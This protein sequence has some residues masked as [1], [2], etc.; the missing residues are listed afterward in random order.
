MKR[1]ELIKNTIQFKS[2]MLA[3]SRR[4]ADAPQGEIDRENGIVRN[5]LVV[6]VGEAQGHGVFCDEQFVQDVANY[7][8][9]QTKGIKCRFG[10]PNMCGNDALGTFIGRF[11]NFRAV[12]G[13]C[14][15]DLHLSEVA[16]KSPQFAGQSLYD[17]ILEMA[18]KESDMFG[19]SIVFAIAGHFM[20]DAKGN[21]TQVDWDLVDAGEPLYVKF[22][23]LHACDCV[24]TPA[25]T[26][27]A[28]TP[29]FS[30]ITNFDSW[31]V[32]AEEYLNINPHFKELIMSNNKGLMGFLA[33]QNLFNFGK[34]PLE[35]EVDTNQKAFAFAAKATDATGAEVAVTAQEDAPKIGSKLFTADAEGNNTPAPDGTYAMPIDG[36]AKQVTVAD[37]SI[38]AIDAV[39]A[40][41][42][43]PADDAQLSADE[44]RFEAMLSGIITK[45]FSGIQK[46]IDDKFSALDKRMEIIE[47]NPQD[48]AAFARG[49]RQDKPAGGNAPVKSYEAFNANIADSIARKTK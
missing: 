12:N 25:A 32:Q 45:Q 26:E 33:K 7:G 44:V 30:Q 2:D 11:K 1:S 39:V 17:Y 9:T 38:S 8:K 5:M 34:K 35:V 31:V 22:G 36:E 48:R 46:S 42:A 47:M 21:P 29:S 40:D 4:S 41:P 20:K 10:H 3:A 49:Q 13:S 15:A 37:G 43:P 14:Y 16:K 27:G 18:D 24:D 23:M 19:N 28:F 6:Q